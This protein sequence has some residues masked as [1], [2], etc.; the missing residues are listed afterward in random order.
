MTY[1][2]EEASRRTPAL[3]ARPVSVWERHFCLRGSPNQLSHPFGSRKGEPDQVAR[4]L[5]LPR[6]SARPPILSCF[7]CRVPYAPFP[8]F[9]RS[10][11]CSLST[12]RPRPWI[13]PRPFLALLKGRFPE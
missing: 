3:A 1:Q 5:P 7:L 10:R 11:P 2:K 6:P 13:G 8:P 4:R 12:S 9:S